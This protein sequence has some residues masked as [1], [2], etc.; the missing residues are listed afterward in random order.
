M[1]YSYDARADALYIR[2]PNTR[3]TRQVEMPDGTIVDTTQDGSL[4]GID[5]MNPGAGW[6]V[7]PVIARWELPESDAALL[8]AIADRWLPTVRPNSLPI[9]SSVGSGQVLKAA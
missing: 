3:P 8:R 6:Q 4:V 9:L 2:F 7:E 5:M 1:N